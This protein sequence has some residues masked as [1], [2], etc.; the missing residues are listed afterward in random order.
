MTEPRLSYQ[1]LDPV[2]SYGSRPITMVFTL[3]IIGFAAGST[4]ANWPLV[5]HPVAAILAVV[6]TAMATIGVGYWSSPLR[7]PFPRI[8][9]LII[10]LLAI[11]GLVLCSAAMWSRPVTV[12]AHWAPITVG[13]I[14]VQLSSYRPAR[15]LAAMTLISSAA[16]A[17]VVG[18]NPVAFH[19]QAPALVLIL[20]QA[21]P[22]LAL[23]AGAAAYSSSVVRSLGRWYS[24]PRSLGQMASP[25]MKERIVESVQ[26]DRISILNDRVIPFLSDVVSNGVVTVDN[27][28]EA[29]AIA[30]SIRSVMV[31]DADRSWLDAVI[32]QVA[33]D[34]G[35]SATPGSEV[36]QDEQR[37]A[38][39]MSTEQ[40]IVVR[41]VLIA[42]FAMPEFDADG[43]AVVIVRE[44]GVAAVTLTAKL[45]LDES[46]PRSGLAAYFAVLRIAFTDLSL[47]FQRPTL[48]LRFS[49]EHK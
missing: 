13:L 38:N 28:E 42:L 34:R 30:D 4:I 6:V 1:Q 3:A 39:S 33:R 32:D 21:L 16:I 11:S 25:A 8:G 22:I 26:H 18:I 48:T 44:Q 17:L 47:S 43:F 24:Q 2:G 19:A 27:R 20:G 29:R 10:M 14:L 23:G 12:V 45:D 36:V 41:A 15:E 46:I 9:F 35:D 40:R 7:A 31:A 49:Y 37:L 5:V